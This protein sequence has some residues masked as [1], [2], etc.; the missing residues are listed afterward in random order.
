MKN[1]FIETAVRI[2]VVPGLLWLVP[3]WSNPLHVDMTGGS[4]T[5][6]FTLTNTGDQT[7]TILR[8]DTPLEAVL[9]SDVFVIGGG[10]VDY[11]GRHIKRATPLARDFLDLAPGQAVRASLALNRFYDIIDHARYEVSFNGAVSYTA[12]V[13][14]HLDHRQRL[15]AMQ[16]A[17]MSTGSVWVDLAPAPP[18]AS[19]LPAGYRFCSVDQQA[20][21]GVALDASESLTVTARDALRNLSE[22]ERSSSPRY[23]HWFG[24]YT[25][26]RYSAVEEGISNAADV[27]AN[28]VINFNCDCDEGAFAYV[29]PNDPFNIYLCRAFWSASVTGTDSQAGTILHELSHFPEIKG[30]DDH[31]YGQS[32]AVA[33]ARTDPDRAINNADSFEYF[34]ENTPDLPMQGD[35][36]S[37]GVQ[38]IAYRTLVPGTSASGSVLVDESMYYQANAVSEVNLVTHSGDADLFVFQDA[39]RLNAL[40]RSRSVDAFDSCNLGAEQ[41]VYIRVDGYQTS[42]YAISVTG[43]PVSTPGPDDESGGGAD[44]GN[45]QADNTNDESDLSDEGSESGS[46]DNGATDTTT[47]VADAGGAGSESGGVD[48]GVT[49]S[50]AGESDADSETGG[51]DNGATDSTTEASGGGDEGSGADD[52]TVVAPGDGTVEGEG[53][54]AE[55][56]SADADEAG[57]GDGEGSASVEPADG[58]ASAESGESSGDAADETDA[59]SSAE[60]D[61]VAGGSANGSDAGGSGESAGVTDAGVAEEVADGDSTAMIDGGNEADGSD[62]GAGGN[63]VDGETDGT[64]NGTGDEADVADGEESAPGSNDE[65]IDVVDDDLDVNGQG[66]SGGGVAA[67][68]LPLLLIAVTRRAHRKHLHAIRD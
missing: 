51:L 59:E 16:S 8:W 58:S 9:S 13:S 33:L 56:G 12:A 66:G 67:L 50:G 25:A 7:L 31:A 29:F 60:T 26:S 17:W 4:G 28:Q 1:R 10:D 45:G 61:D 68:G 42:T 64:T 14:K 62:G 47:E 24:A 36:E 11:T 19:A 57:S 52:S 6:T 44:N 27:M 46:A 5:V 41:S 35:V 54:D 15:A 38:T 22:A 49:E 48:N 23:H 18:T 2:A 43:T 63:M 39:Q 37:G 40:C 65:A 32:A 34:V 21:I 20:Q 53:S 55:G 3:V 30:T